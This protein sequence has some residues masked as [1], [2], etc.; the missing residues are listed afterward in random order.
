MKK[1]LQS[2]PV[3]LALPIHTW[4]RKLR[5]GGESSW[6]RGKKSKTHGSIGIENELT[7]KDI[8]EAA[9]LIIAADTKIR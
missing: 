5:E 7:A 3:Q 4:R 2:H 9:G 1:L 6:R 8:E